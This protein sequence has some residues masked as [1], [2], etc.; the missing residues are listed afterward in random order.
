MS[1]AQCVILVPV[2]G[3]IEPECDHALR[4][5]EQRGYVVRRVAGYSAVDQARNHMATDALKD[6]FEELMWIDSDVVFDPDAI[7]R[8]RSHD[9][10]IVCGIYP[11]KGVRELACAVM[12]GTGALRFGTLGGL[13]ELEYGATG[14]LYT[15]ARVYHDIKLKLGLPDCNQRYNRLVTPYFLPMVIPDLDVPN[16]H[17]YLGEDFS[18]LERAKRCG[19]RVF[20]D[21]TIR[22]MHVGR[23]FYQWEDAG[24]QLPRHVSYKLDIRANEIPKLRK[25]ESEG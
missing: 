10:P 25:V 20:A 8:L 14:F 3:A 1:N 2:G 23:Y 22:L 5:L 18:F 17:R 7:D 12:P 24:S 13:V 6:G 21:T 4:L 15:R 19:Y 16:G 9:L 11:K